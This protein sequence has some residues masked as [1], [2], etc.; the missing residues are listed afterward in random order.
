MCAAQP[1]WSGLAEATLHG[2]LPMMP[3]PI[4]AE[5]LG[6]CTIL[7]MRCCGVGL[8]EEVRRQVGQAAEAL[9]ALA[10]HLLGLLALQEL[11][12]QAADRLR[13]LH[14][15]LVGL[16][17]A[18]A[19]ER[20]QADGA[21]LRDRGEG[22]G[23]ER[24]GRLERRL[25]EH[26]LA[27]LPGVAR[28][29]EELLGG[30]LAREPAFL[31][32]DLAARRIDP[33]AAAVVPALDVA[34]GAQAGL[35]A[36]GDAVRLGERARHGMLQPQ[37]LLAALLRRDVAADA[38]VALE[39]ALGVEQRLAA[40]REPHAAAV[41]QRALDL[42]VAERLVALQAAPVVLPVVVGRVEAGLGGE[43]LGGVREPQLAVHLPVPVGEKPAERGRAITGKCKGERQNRR[44]YSSLRCSC[45]RPEGPESG[46]AFCCYASRQR[47]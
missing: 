36:L 13:R 43:G 26:R 11:A 28:A 21:A 23:G 32:R 25:G 45:Q 7:V 42:E 16:A 5:P 35:Q 41:A 37:E 34:D 46:R 17:G 31:Q 4:C 15:A 18:V 1:A 9:L 10:Q 14:Q 6:P 2:C 3:R 8:P 39:H 33:E 20:E 22:E 38:A 24:A 12:E 44:L 19:G 30:G 40:Q 29:A 47:E 27:V